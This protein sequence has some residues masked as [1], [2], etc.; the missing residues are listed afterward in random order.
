MHSCFFVVFGFFAK[1][2]GHFTQG[3]SVLSFS[4]EINQNK[5]QNPIQL[6]HLKP[7]AK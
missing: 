7:D 5:T 2:H 1:L 6:S 4:K 3:Y